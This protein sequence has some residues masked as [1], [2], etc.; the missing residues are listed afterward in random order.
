M[1]QQIVLKDISVQRAGHTILKLPDLSYP[2]PS[3]IALVGENGA[4]KTTLLKAL[5]GIIK[6]SG[7]I[8]A[9]CEDSALGIPPAY[10][11][12]HFSVERGGKMSVRD[13]LSVAY[14]YI[15]HK[16]SPNLD[17]LIRI[18]LVDYDLVH[19]ASKS[20]SDLSGGELQ[21][22]LL[23][24][25]LL[26]PSRLVLLDE[27]TNHLDRRRRETVIRHLTEECNKQRTIIF[28]THDL[29]FALSCA[30]ALVILEAG[31]VICHGE[32]NQIIS[33]E[34]FQ[35]RY[36]TICEVHFSAGTKTYVPEGV[37]PKMRV[38]RS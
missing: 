1:N 30:H 18:A 24:A 28:A 19:V 36:G 37:F 35:R 21:M 29:L 9:P 5:G 31:D 32:T 10:L 17:P 15:L 14:P 2:H 38:I 7:E 26:S 13:F 25:T 6:A 12:Q 3:I 33:C 16:V 20:L 34:L 4:G 27:P 11:P 8:I 23:A 22:V